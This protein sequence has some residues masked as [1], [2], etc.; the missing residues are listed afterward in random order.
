MN[1]E[2]IVKLVDIKLKLFS[3]SN[4]INSDKLY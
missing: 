2:N 3:V 1:K 4:Y